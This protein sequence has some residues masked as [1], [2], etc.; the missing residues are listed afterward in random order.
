MRSMNFSLSISQQQ[1]QQYYTGKIK[2]V[3]VTADDGRR[4]KFPADILQKLVTH[5]G[6]HGRFRIDFDDQHKFKRIVRL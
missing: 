1:Y 3:V 5:D 6:V 2:F 4:V